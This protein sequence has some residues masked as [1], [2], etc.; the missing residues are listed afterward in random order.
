MHYTGEKNKQIRLFLST[1]Y[2]YLPHSAGSES[3]YLLH[4]KTRIFFFHISGSGI[5]F[6]SE[7]RLHLA[8]AVPVPSCG[9]IPCT[10]SMSRRHV[11]AYQCFS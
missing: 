3:D 9:T 11:G 6:G 1:R 8:L 7:N 4:E 10:K 5:L 2:R